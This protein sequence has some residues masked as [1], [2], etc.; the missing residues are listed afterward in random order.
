MTRCRAVLALL[1]GLA[2]SPAVA[3]EWIGQ[4]QV[5]DGDTLDMDSTRLRL[6]GIDAPEPGQS[7]M[8]REG[9]TYDC[10]AKAAEA[11]VQLI[12]DQ[13]VRCRS[14]GRN[15]ENLPLVL[16]SAGSIDLNSELVRLGW[17]V[18]YGSRD[19]Q[20]REDEARVAARGLWQGRFQRPEDW[21][22]ERTRK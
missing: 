9:A 8:D 7:C 16:C 6:F 13:A 17:A 5:V 11:L 14:V 12:G 10:G 18:T 15:P 22:R 3:A 20:R 1:A 19:Y 21:R 4:A 2:S